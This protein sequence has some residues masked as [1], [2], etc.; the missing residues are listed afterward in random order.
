LV[1]IT[2]GDGGGIGAHRDRADDRI[3]LISRENIWL[4]T[5][6]IAGQLS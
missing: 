6:A 5:A 1:S 2:D 3:R 4:D